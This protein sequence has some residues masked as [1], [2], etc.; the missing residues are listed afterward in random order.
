MN[1]TAKHRVVWREAQIEI[2]LS[3]EMRFMQDGYGNSL[4][5]PSGEFIE[6]SIPNHHDP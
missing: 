1:R 5:G 6:R 2:E 4:L 3:G